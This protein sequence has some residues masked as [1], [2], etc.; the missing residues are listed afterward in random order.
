MLGTPLAAPVPLA[1]PPSD[2]TKAK[3]DYFGDRI[4]ASSISEPPRGA[5]GRTMMGMPHSPLPP[6]PEGGHPVPPQS[7]PRA[8]GRTMLGLP[9]AAMPNSAQ[10]SA[11]QPNAALP[12]TR[13]GSARR[14]RPSRLSTAR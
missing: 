2:A 1:E 7:S 8:A 4:T 14:C 9:N 10:P 12:T 3:A 5:I 11:G 6:P 13:R